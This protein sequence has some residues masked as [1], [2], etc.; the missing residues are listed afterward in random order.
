MELQVC[1][2]LICNVIFVCCFLGWYRGFSIR[3]KSLKVR[4]RE[5]S[6]KRR[7]EEESIK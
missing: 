2:H 1:V 3:D 7:E 5:S 6:F 4:K